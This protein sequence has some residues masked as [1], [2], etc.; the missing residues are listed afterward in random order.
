[1][2]HKVA[3]LTCLLYRYMHAHVRLTAYM[4]RGAEIIN[5][6]IHNHTHI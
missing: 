6:A 2:W 3:R 5:S 1:M 4:H